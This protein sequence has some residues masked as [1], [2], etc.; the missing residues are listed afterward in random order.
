MI[1]R[2]GIVLLVFCAAGSAVAASLP[3][4]LDCVQT[5]M[6]GC[7]GGE[8]GVCVDGMGGNGRRYTFNLEQGSFETPDGRGK[9]L[10]IKH[11]PDGVATLKLSNR[12][13]LSINL[14]FKDLDGK[15]S[16]RYA[17]V[18]RPVKGYLIPAIACDAVY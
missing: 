17:P 2:C 16:P 11:L 7:G 1:L 8:D 13:E 4:R 15:I 18:P 14:N 10:A 12:Y 9:I 5:G 6:W 3:K